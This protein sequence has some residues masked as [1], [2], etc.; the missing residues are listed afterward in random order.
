MNLFYHLEHKYPELYSELCKATQE[1]DEEASSSAPT[2]KSVKEMLESRLKLSRTSREH[3]DLTKIVTRFLVKDMVPEYTVEKPGF[4]AMLETFN[5][6]YD[7]P[8]RNYF[9]RVAIP[10]LYSEVKN[11][12]QQK[13]D[14]Q[15]L[16]FY[17]GT[18]DLWSSITSEP[19]LSYTV[20]FIDNNWNLHAKCLQTH[21]IPEA[22]TGV[23]LKE[24]LA[25][26]LNQWHLNPD[27]QVAIT[28]DSGTNIKLACEL[29]IGIG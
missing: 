14:N 16:T 7:L 17:A 27:N 21:Y 28:T 10:S 26:S 22:H 20:H 19:Y 29:L 5:P 23:N 13:I 18:T 6:R 1:K 11:N 25:S 12:L 2:M 24:V 4:R 15:H 3:K 8:S 9:S